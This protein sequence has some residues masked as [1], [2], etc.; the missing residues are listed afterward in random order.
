MTGINR[1]TLSSETLLYA[2]ASDDNYTDCYETSVAVRLTLEDFVNAFYT[3]WLFKL[4][5]RLLHWIV[6]RPSSDDDV[7]RLAAGESDQFAA[8]H[9]ERRHAQEILLCD[10]NGAT[11]SWLMVSPANDDANRTTLRF[12][13]AVV[14]GERGL[15][16]AFRALL[17]FHKLYSRLL[18]RAARS[19]LVRTYT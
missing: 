7:R 13:S 12:G 10:M 6:K 1:S 5:R 18:L 8:W 9:V 4:E 14:A 19:R 2:Y 11:R 16:P 3:T 17:G 15:G